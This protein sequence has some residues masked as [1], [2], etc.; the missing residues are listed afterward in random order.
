MQIAG[1]VG[2]VASS[3]AINQASKHCR[4]IGSKVENR[5]SSDQHGSG[6][7]EILMVKII[8]TRTLMK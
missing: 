3:R 4:F 8:Q 2:A 1:S 6:D 7:A 5:L